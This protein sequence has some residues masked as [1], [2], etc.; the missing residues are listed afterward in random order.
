MSSNIT[1]Y[2]VSSGSGAQKRPRQDVS[3][4]ENDDE[5]A[6]LGEGIYIY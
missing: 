5:S 2:F 3:N 6:I 1:K 4:S